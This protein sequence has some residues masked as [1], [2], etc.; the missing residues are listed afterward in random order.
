MASTVSPRYVAPKD[1]HHSQTRLLAPHDES[2]PT[3]AL[4][5]TCS[6][7]RNHI[8]TA[9]TDSPD[10][11][12][13][14]MPMRT[15]LAWVQCLKALIASLL[16]WTC[17]SPPHPSCCPCYGSARAGVSEII[18][19]GGRAFAAAAQSGRDFLTTL[20]LIRCPFVKR[21]AKTVRWHP[22]A[23]HSVHIVTAVQCDSI[24]RNSKDYGL[25]LTDGRVLLRMAKK[26]PRWQAGFPMGLAPSAVLNRDIC[27]FGIEYNPR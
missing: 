8:S 24:Q 20:F 3:C 5:I 2:A 23:Q 19:Q 16:S 7:E 4:N 13:L 1:S 15:I 22:R 9:A 12:A 17:R 25:F 6:R 21:V 27:G 14:P 18:R 26:W 11:V 10:R